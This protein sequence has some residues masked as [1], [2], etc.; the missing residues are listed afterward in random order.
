MM[1]RCRHH[2]SSRLPL[3]PLSAALLLALG[4]TGVPILAQASDDQESSERELDRVVVTATRREETAQEA[5]INIT[6]VTGSDIEERGLKNL[7][8]LVRTVPG[9]F[10]VDQ[11]G[12]DANLL[13]VRGLNVDPLAA[14]EGV[15]LASGGVVAQYI[16]DI[17]LF[18]DLRLFDLDR[19]EALLGP[20]G[21]LYGAGTLG[22]AIRYLPM[23]PQ[24]EETS[25]VFSTGLIGLSQSSDIG[26]ESQAIANLPL[27]SQ[28]ALRASVAYYDDPGFI[29]YGYVLRQPGISNPEPAPG[30]FD[31]NL[32][33][34]RD[35]NWTRTLAG[36]I[37]FLYDFDGAADL[38]LSY[39]FQ[40]Q[41]AGGRT[42]NHAESFGTGR[43]ESAGRY[44][45]PNTRESQL[46]S[47]EVRAD[48]GFAELTSAT[49]FS[50][51][52]EHGQRDQTDL[53]L[54]FEYGYEDFPAFSSFTRETVDQDRFNQELRL[55]STHAGPWNWIVGAFYNRSD[56]EA[57]SSEFVPG[58]PAFWGID[59]PDELEYFQATFNEFKERAVFGEIGYDLSD[60]WSV[61]FGARRFRFEDEQRVGFALPLIDDSGPNEILP[62]F[63]SVSVRDSDTIFKF[64]TAYQFHPELLGY[65]TVSEGYRSGGS[66]AV[67]PCSDPLEPG[68]NVCALP[69]ERL[70]QPDKTRNHELGLKSSLLDNRLLLNAAIYY[71]QWK[72]IQV[73][74]QT[75]NGSIPIT[76]NASEAT[77][78]G[79]ELSAAARIADGWRLSAGYA[80]NQA[81]LSADAPGIV[82]GEDAFDGDRL[83]GSPR[84]QGNLALNWYRPLANGLALGADYALYGQSDV[85][86]RVG[87]RAGGETLGGYVTHDA[88]LSLSG[89]RWSVRFYVRNLFDKYAE[90]GVRDTRN[91]IYRIDGVAD[92]G[93]DPTHS[94]A[95]RRYHKAVL[96]PRR[97]GVTLRYEF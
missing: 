92:D 84:H 12:R 38:N 75:V 16:G 86:T 69:N 72:D 34:V 4:G 44:L 83:P 54:A 51:Y 90:T 18:L 56:L 23:R 48:L 71:I 58:I 77:S 32:R 55:V 85:Y 81:K 66:N 41:R 73:A 46:L 94:F 88:A 3:R 97:Y 78:R 82:R 52:D 5:P 19:V 11:G 61:S 2:R 40:R 29:D 89:D 63:E 65:L 26:S 36:R 1:R 60:A 13:T 68:Q 25:F 53:L 35:A 59:R 76:V 24:L 64:N 45:E 22:G 15:G 67:P 74:G 6:A 87:L 27:G 50:R 62:S 93:P 17:P 21:T 9:L 37:G 95:L 70:I 91:Q 8:D 20:Q 42:V 49:G 7:A 10:L 39:H 31:A 57:T 28:A 33:R 30:D 96:E 47:L 79:L 14:S 43:Y 80:Y